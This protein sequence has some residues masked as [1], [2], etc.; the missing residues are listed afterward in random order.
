M[1]FTNELRVVLIFVDFKSIPV[2][3]IPFDENNF[4]IFIPNVV[5]KVLLSPFKYQVSFLSLLLMIGNDKSRSSNNPYP[6]CH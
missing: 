6:A 1:D 2:K 4:E 3:I 5:K